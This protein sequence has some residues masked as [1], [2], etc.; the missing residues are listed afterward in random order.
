MVVVLGPSRPK[1]HHA[2]D[3][4]HSRSTT[5]SDSSSAP[6]A[7]PDKRGERRARMSGG[8]WIKA[9]TAP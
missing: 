1:D 5:S 3:L 2:Y 9:A 6:S 7:D 4:N 8:E